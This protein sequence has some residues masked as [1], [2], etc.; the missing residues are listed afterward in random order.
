M[1]GLVCTRTTVILILK[2]F[3]KIG[4]VPFTLF[5]D[6]KYFMLLTLSASHHSSPPHQTKHQ[7]SAACAMPTPAL[8]SAQRKHYLT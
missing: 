6:R 4:V 8:H 3:E 1:G 5:L 2:R 7:N